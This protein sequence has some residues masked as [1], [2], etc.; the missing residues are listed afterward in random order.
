MFVFFLLVFPRLRSVQ[1]QQHKYY[2]CLLRDHL[3]DIQVQFID[4]G[5]ADI[6]DNI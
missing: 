4:N 3:R 2:N 1:E 5:L 6:A